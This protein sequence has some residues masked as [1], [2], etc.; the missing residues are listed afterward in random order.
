MQVLLTHSVPEVEPLAVPGGVHV[1][2]QVQLVEP[3]RDPSQ[4]GHGQ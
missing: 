1:R 3:V 2:P 4:D